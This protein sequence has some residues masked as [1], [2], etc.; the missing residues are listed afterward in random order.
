MPSKTSQHIAFYV[1]LVV[2]VIFHRYVYAN[3]KRILLRDYPKLGPKLV[4]IARWVFI[5]MDTPF[6][7]V[8]F[9]NLITFETDFIT[10]LILYPFLVWQT[11]MLMWTIILVPFSII[12]REKMGV[13]Y[14][15]RKIRNRKLSKE[16][17][18]KNDL[19]LEIATK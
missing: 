19:G 2:S 15:K 10:R 11:I 5:A 18:P 7:F 6:F 13:A 1:V 16:K 17:F 12:R 14:I 3:L 8:Y 9:R 4:R